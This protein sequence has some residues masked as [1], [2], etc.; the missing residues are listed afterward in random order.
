MM[1]LLMS[2]DR[3]EILALRGIAGRGLSLMAGILHVHCSACCVNE[4][5]AMLGSCTRVT[6]RTATGITLHVHGSARQLP[7]SLRS[8]KTYTRVLG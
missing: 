2:P 7:H 4:R 8:L 1:A 6:R 3:E 5:A